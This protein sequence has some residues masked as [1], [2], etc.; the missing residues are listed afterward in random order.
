MST[1]SDVLMVPSSTSASRLTGN[2][3]E[4]TTVVTMRMKV[5]AMRQEVDTIVFNIALR[6][7]KVGNLLM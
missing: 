6:F 7:C 5:T 3:M 2:A 4:R 1:S